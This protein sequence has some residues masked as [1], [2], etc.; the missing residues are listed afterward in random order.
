MDRIRASATKMGVL[1]DDLLTLARIT[2]SELVPQ[3]VNL[4]TVAEEIA[5][6]LRNSQPER[7]VTF[8]IEPNLRAVG[9]RAG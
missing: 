4:S 7:S 3:D 6:Q 8:V 2:R 5:T 1:I 9:D